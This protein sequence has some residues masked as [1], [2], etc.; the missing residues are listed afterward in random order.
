MEAEVLEE[1]RQF[2]RIFYSAQAVISFDEKLYPCTVL[3]ISLKGCLLEFDEDWVLPI[4]QLYSLTLTLGEGID[5]VMA[6]SV[7]HVVGHQVGLKC[8]HIDI[9]SISRL[10]RMIELNLGDSQLLERDL[11]MLSEITSPK[12]N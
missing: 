2:H 8:E 1:K 4:D 11:A 5:I 7:V 12:N 9:D 6:M 10:R 3:D